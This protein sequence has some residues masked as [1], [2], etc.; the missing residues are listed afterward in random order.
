MATLHGKSLMTSQRFGTA[1]RNF[2]NVTT[3]DMLHGMSIVRRKVKPLYPRDT[4]CGTS[5]H[6]KRIPKDL[7]QQWF[8]TTNHADMAQV[9]DAA[10]YLK[11][12]IA[13][14]DETPKAQVPTMKF[15]RISRQ[16]QHSDIFDTGDVQSCGSLCHTPPTTPLMPAYRVCHATA[17]VAQDDDDEMP[18]PLHFSS[19]PTTNPSRFADIKTPSLPNSNSAHVPTDDSPLRHHNTEHSSNKTRPHS[20]TPLLATTTTAFSPSTS[21]RSSHNSHKS[22]IIESNHR[23]KSSVP[24]KFKQLISELHS[25]FIISDNYMCK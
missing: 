19:N 16:C 4:L 12:H 3:H 21:P 17:A 15:K 1:P 25:K 14:N 18:L 9:A 23:I 13:A 22:R 20:A 2:D 10:K 8:T 5:L 11:F 7:I 6:T 24:H